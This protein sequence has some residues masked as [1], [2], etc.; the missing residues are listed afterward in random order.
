MAIISG[1]L[2]N[3]CTSNKFCLHLVKTSILHFDILLPQLRVLLF[4]QINEG[5]QFSSIL[6]LG[7]SLL[8]F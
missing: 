1:D 6:Q 3:M 8:T 7:I 2:S 4:P 5:L